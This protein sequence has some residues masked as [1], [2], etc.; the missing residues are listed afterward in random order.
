MH[1]KIKDIFLSKLTNKISKVKI[2]DYHNSEVRIGKV[3]DSTHLDFAGKFLRQNAE[4]IFWGGNIDF[5]QSIIYP[6][7]ILTALKEIQNYTEFFSP[8][9]FVSIYDS[10]D[11]LSLFFKR[12]E[13]LAAAMYVSIFGDI[14]RNKWVENS[15]ILKN[16]NILDVE[17]GNKPY[18]GYGPKANFISFN[19]YYIH[20]PILIS[21]EIYEYQRLKSKNPHCLPA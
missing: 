15:V 13:Y 4:K 3:I 7:I 1:S 14:K 19:R 17:E 12:K 20:R 6:T 9:F 8:I 18:G 10:E 21:K 11:D 5:K 2:G 16:K